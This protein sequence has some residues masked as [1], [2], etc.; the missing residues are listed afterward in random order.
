MA[1]IFQKVKGERVKRNMFNL[2]HEQKL[3]LNMGTLVPIFNQEVVPGDTFRVNSEVMLRFAPLLAPIMHRVNVYT[4]FFYVPNRIIWNE[5]EDFISGNGEVVFP[6]LRINPVETSLNALQQYCKN[7]SLADYLGVPEIG[8]VPTRNIDLSALPFR[9]YQT[10]FNEYYRDQDLIDEVTVDKSSGIT[11]VVDS[12]ELMKLRQRAW[13]KDYFTSARPWAQKG[14]DVELPLGGTAP[15]AYNNPYGDPTQLRNATDGSTI[16]GTTG[17]YYSDTN[18]EIFDTDNLVP[19]AFD[20]SKNHVVDLS[21]ATSATITELRRAFQLQKWLERNARSGTRYTELL[22]A[23]F[24]VKSSDGRLQRPEYLGGGRQSVS[25][26]EVLQTS[27]SDAESSTGDMAGHG[28]SIGNSNRFKRFFEEHG[29]IIGIMSIIPRTSYQQGLSRSFQKFDKFDYFWKEFAHIGEQ[30]IKNSELYLG[31][32]S[33]DDDTFGYAPRYSEYKYV[34]SQVHGD[35]RGNL[36]YWHMGRKFV[37]RPQLN[38]DFIN[39]NPTDR[40]FNVVDQDVQK[41]WCH[42]YHNVKALRPMPV[43]GEPG[44]IDH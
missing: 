43:F 30:E 6:R 9:A 5:W 28:M 27:K 24:G 22:Q 12:M 17:G 36:D 7:G 37:N 2:S 25:I 20:V 1:N 11:D 26:S 18:G 40:I 15:L 33:E 34:P 42:I 31:G 29:Q 8:S 19:A 4:H 10:I 23:H 14:A 32:D 21:S 16:D 38:E 35:F 41:I 13:E 39:S 44:L 3:S